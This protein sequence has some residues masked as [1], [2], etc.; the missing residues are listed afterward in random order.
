MEHIQTRSRMKQNQCVGTFGWSSVPRRC[1]QHSELDTDRVRLHWR[2][3]P[4]FF[5]RATHAEPNRCSVPHKTPEMTSGCMRR[6]GMRRDKL[7]KCVR[8]T[9]RLNTWTV[10]R[11]GMQRPHAVVSRSA[12]APGKSELAERSTRREINCTHASE[13]RAGSTHGQRDFKANIAQK[14]TKS[15]HVRY[16][17]RRRMAATRATMISSFAPSAASAEI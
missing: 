14:H 15:K 12:D 3:G 13:T 11:Q 8:N 2:R 4:F 6:A 9:S 7:H 16:D 5:P 17:V 10:R 1:R